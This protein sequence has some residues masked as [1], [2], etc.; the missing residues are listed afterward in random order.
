THPKD[1]HEVS[2][3]PRKQDATMTV[4][5]QRQAFRV[6]DRNPQR[7]PG[8]VLTDH[9]EVAAYTRQDVLRFHCLVRILIIP[10]LVV[11][12]PDIIRL[13]MHQQRRTRIRR[14]IKPGQTLDGTFTLL[15]DVDDDI[16][17]LVLHTGQRQTELLAHRTAPAIACDHP[18]CTHR[19]HRV[20]LA[21][22][23]IST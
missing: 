11:D 18:V 20:A 17:S 5:I 22:L 19:L 6:I 9:L 8:L 10:D 21:Y 12:A 7:L 16:A 13:S 14:R 1:R 4:V 2:G 15:P 23:D 3:V